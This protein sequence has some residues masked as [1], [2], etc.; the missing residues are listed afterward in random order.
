[1]AQGHLCRPAWVASCRW[2]ASCPYFR[3][4]CCLFRHSSDE[5]AA[6][7]LVG[8]DS[9]IMESVPPAQPAPFGGWADHPVLGCDVAATASLDMLAERV[10]QLER[11]VEQIVVAPAPQTW[12]PLG[13][14]LSSSHH[15]SACRI[16]RKI[17]F[18]ILDVL[19]LRSRRTAC[20]SYH[21]SAS[22]IARGSKLWM[23][24]CLKSRRTDCTSY[25][26]SAC[27]IVRRS[28]L[29]MSSCLRSRRTAC[30]S[31]HRSAS[32]IARR[33]QIVDVL[34]PQNMG[35]YA[36]VVHATPQEL[37]QNRSFVRQTTKE[38]GDGVQHVPSKCMPGRHGDS[39]IKGLDKYNMPCAGVVSDMI[40]TGF[41][42]VADV[43]R[44]LSHGRTRD[45]SVKKEIA[46]K[47][48]PK[49]VFVDSGPPHSA[50]KPYTGKVFTVEM[51]HQHVHQAYP[52]DYG[53]F[54]V[55]GL[56]KY[57]MPR[58]GDVMVT[59]LD[60]E[61]PVPQIV[62]ELV[63]RPEILERIIKRFGWSMSSSCSSSTV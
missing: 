45:V 28:K 33:E 43:F 4:G 21:R 41:V 19:C 53:V 37:V 31:Y 29:W 36:G 26:R 7:S 9:E 5:V 13:M 15:R 17:R 24:S 40:P 6:A 25:H 59:A 60:I 46:V 32:K 50:S 11:V 18:W 20:T 39:N 14:K 12:E 2:G 38:I 47:K 42:R 30:T 57:N 27:K 44:P 55:K 51:P 58:S 16:A 61:V 10:T 54:N 8:Q 48:G 23:S 34:V 1:M 63:E 52:G 56:D 22:K 49:R 35:D 3:R 62:E